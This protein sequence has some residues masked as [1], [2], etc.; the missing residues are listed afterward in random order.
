[1]RAT[2]GGSREGL[3]LEVLLLT[4]WVCIVVMLAYRVF[5]DER[6]NGELGLGLFSYRQ[7]LR[8]ARPQAR[9]AERNA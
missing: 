8:N 4:L 2:A 7:T 6:R 5:R 9:K 1:M 3:G